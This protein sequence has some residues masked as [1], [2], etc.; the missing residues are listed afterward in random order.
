M[1]HCILLRQAREEF[2]PTT[3]EVEYIK[4]KYEEER[5]PNPHLPCVL[6]F[7]TKTVTLEP[8]VWSNVS[9]K[10]LLVGKAKLPTTL[11][12]VVMDL[13]QILGRAT[14]LIIVNLEQALTLYSKKARMALRGSQSL[15]ELSLPL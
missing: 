12:Q 8:I 10:T 5:A 13:L 6:E 1:E 4:K 9:K 15:K 11:Q 2:T 7:D 14:L 3:E